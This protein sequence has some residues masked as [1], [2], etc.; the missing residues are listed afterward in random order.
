MLTAQN[1]TVSVWW[2]PWAADTLP[3]LWNDSNSDWQ[4]YEPATTAAQDIEPNEVGCFGPFSLSGSSPTSRYVVLAQATCDD[5]MANIVPEAELPCGREET[6]LVDLV[7][8][9]NNLGLR[10]FGEADNP[11]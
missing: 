10:V 2:C 8:N 6:P 9:D 3:P 7:A 4:P 5:D 1:V 11:T